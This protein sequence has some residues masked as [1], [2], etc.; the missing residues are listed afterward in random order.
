MARWEDRW[1]VGK[2]NRKKPK[3]YLFVCFARVPKEKK[4]TR[5]PR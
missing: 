4:E 5:D 1:S 3:E 2:V